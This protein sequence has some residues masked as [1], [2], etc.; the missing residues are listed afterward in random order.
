M[1]DETAWKPPEDDLCV[2]ETPLSWWEWPAF[3]LL[4]AGV[5]GLIVWAAGVR[6]GWW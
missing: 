3:I 5:L 6:A 4:L 1:P 2:H